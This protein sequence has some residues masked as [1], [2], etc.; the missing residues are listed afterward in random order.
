MGYAGVSVGEA[1]GSEEVRQLPQAVLLRRLLEGND[2]AEQD[3]HAC[4]DLRQI[5][6]YLHGSL[7]PPAES[8][9]TLFVELQAPFAF[10]VGISLENFSD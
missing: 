9:M 2:A 1:C 5:S 4:Q 6:V 8:F 10:A 3:A 7:S